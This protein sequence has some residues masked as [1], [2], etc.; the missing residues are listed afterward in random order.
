M[1]V[2]HA[3]V[4]FLHEVLS[5]TDPVGRYIRTTGVVESF[6]APSSC[7]IISHKGETFPIDAELIRSEISVGSTYQVFGEVQHAG[8]K[9]PQDYDIET[10]FNIFVLGDPWM[11][12]AQ[13]YS[14]S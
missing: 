11:R 4:L 8:E 2:P 12:Y 10:A 5:V 6:D 1:S 14:E 7:C 13:V 9:V 3:E